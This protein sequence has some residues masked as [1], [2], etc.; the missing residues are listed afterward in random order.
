MTLPA[1]LLVACTASVSPSVS[2]TPTPS[3]TPEPTIAREPPPPIVLAAGDIAACDSTGDELTA[4]LLDTLEG[5]VLTLGDNIYPDG[6]A[7]EFADCY[8]PSWGRHLARTYPSA[9]NHDYQTEA[10]AAYFA[11]F[12]TAAGTPGEAWYSY[13]VGSWHVV[14][15]NSN[16]EEV[17]GCGPD[18][19]QTAWLLADLAAHAES[20]CTLA[21]WHHPRWS[22]G[23]QHG[24]DPR[25]DT[26]WRTLYA[27]G[28]DLVLT[29]HDH[30]YERF[31][32]MD[33]EGNTAGP[34]MVEFVVGTGGRSL[35]EFGTALPTSAVRDHS[36]YGVLKLTLHP[37]RYDWEFVAASDTG[38]ADAGSAACR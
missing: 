22:S 4:E 21:Y 37:D 28:A 7:T 1:L 19:P 23:E 25:T 17:G 31:V 13:G 29:A 6:T 10:A 38:F 34:G 11:Y 24:S 9:G 16:C 2:P 15:L 5:L 14:V 26:L 3:P 30:L 33:A 35:Y 12:G 8:D 32:P 36:T 18:S 20:A 27:A